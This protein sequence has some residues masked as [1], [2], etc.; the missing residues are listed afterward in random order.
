[1]LFI[2]PLVRAVLQLQKKK[3]SVGLGKVQY[4]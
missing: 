3:M 2:R 4:A 1:M